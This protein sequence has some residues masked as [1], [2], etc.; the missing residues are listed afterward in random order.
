MSDIY[1]IN[2]RTPDV[3]AETV[4]TQ[5]HGC[6]TVA[7]FKKNVELATKVPVDKQILVF[8]SS[9]MEDHYLIDDYH[10]NCQNPVYIELYLK[11]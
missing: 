2:H 6:V 9:V 7:D 5:S 1:I 4:M 8:V 10:F 3:E 11:Q